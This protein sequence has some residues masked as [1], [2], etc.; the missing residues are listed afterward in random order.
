MPR[1]W[2]R[3]S[4]TALKPV[5]SVGDR[6]EA[7]RPFTIFLLS[8]QCSVV[9][10]FSAPLTDLS[11]VSDA[12]HTWLAFR[13]RSLSL[14]GAVTQYIVPG[15]QGKEKVPERLK[16]YSLRLVNTPERGEKSIPSSEQPYKV[17][18]KCPTFASLQVKAPGNWKN[19]WNNT[20]AK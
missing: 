3:I 1:R 13:R 20:W 9:A 16:T 15:F 7:Q 14:N 18:L 5:S 11:S 8:S 4:L 12:S 17:A 2:L 10:L 19:K 6:K